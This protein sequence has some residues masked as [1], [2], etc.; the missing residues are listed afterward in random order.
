M[1]ANEGQFKFLWDIRNML[2]D[3]G[4]SVAILVL[5]YGALPYSFI[6]ALAKLTDRILQTLPPKSSILTSFVKR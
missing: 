3:M 5:S 1:P 6:T 2:N 4:R